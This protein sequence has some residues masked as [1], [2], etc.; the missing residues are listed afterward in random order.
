MISPAAGSV[1]GMCQTTSCDRVRPHRGLDLRADRDLLAREQTP[2]QELAVPR[3]DL[4]RELRRLVGR[5]ADAG[6]ADLHRIEERPRALDRDDA[7]RAFLEAGRLV[8]A[9]GVAFGDD[10]LAGQVLAGEIVRR[11]AADPHEFARG[12]AGH[13][14][15]GQHR[16]H[17]QVGRQLLADRRHFPQF[18]LHR[19]PGLPAG[20]R[21]DFSAGQPVG[22]RLVEEELR[23]VEQSRELVGRPVLVVPA[24]FHDHLP[25]VLAGRLAHDLR[26]L[27]LGQQGPLQPRSHLRAHGAARDERNSTDHQDHSASHHVSFDLRSHVCRC[28]QPVVSRT[29]QLP[30]DVFFYWLLSTGY[31]LLNLTEFRLSLAPCPRLRLRPVGHLPPSATSRQALVPCPYI[32]PVSFQY[33]TATHRAAIVTTANAVASRRRSPSV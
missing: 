33:P 6:P 26:H 9:P 32:S 27:R 19:V 7:Q 2:L 10:D 1:P 4:E 31:L 30:A 12:L 5:A 20:E 25:R 28:Q 23:F 21:H 29:E 18:A 11:A 16:G 15:G 24:G 3:R 14:S 13:A 8:H 17:V 22:L